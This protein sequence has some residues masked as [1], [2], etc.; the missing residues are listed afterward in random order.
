[1]NAYWLTAKHGKIGQIY[2]IGGNK[3]I[4][5]KDYLKEL[6]KLSNKKI[7]LKLDRSLLR[8][9]DVTLQLPSVAKF[10]KEVRWKPK[11]SFKKS[12]KKLLDDC[13]KY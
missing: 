2:N 8:P 9:T 7:V 5:V 12:V 1:M 11:V 3:I 6:M 13:R 4:S 10:K